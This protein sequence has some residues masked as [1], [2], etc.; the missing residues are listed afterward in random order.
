MV[1]QHAQAVRAA[2]QL[3]HEMEQLIAQ[4]GT[5]AHPRGQV[6]TAYRG[7]RQALQT[8]LTGESTLATR[9][10]DGQA[11][12][13]GLR[14]EL[15]STADD[16]LMAANTVGTQA[17]KRQADIYGIATQVPI[18]VDTQAARAAWL[19][20]FEAQAAQIEAALR[21]DNPD[22]ILGDG[23]AR[24]GL[25]TPAPMAR[26]G[27]RWLVEVA[28]GAW[29]AWLLQSTKGTGEVWAHQAVAAIDALTTDCCLRVHGQVQPLGKPFH[30]TG[31]PR[32][33]DDLPHSPFHWYCRTAE[34]LVLISQAKDQLTDEMRQAARD[35]LDARVRTGKRETIWPSHA[36][37]RRGQSS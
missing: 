16:L 7:A 12:M 36:R 10:M 34:A 4:V 35:E 5:L 11:V 18:M 25:L 13:A 22:V 9:I 24:L 30:L 23:E 26:D 3:S 14:R 37:S 31:T 33:A 19:G 27:S 2:G 32:Y 21:L 1:D 29:L 28:L 15:H 6:L 8:I 20:T 17:A